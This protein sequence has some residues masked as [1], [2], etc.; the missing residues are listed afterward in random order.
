MYQCFVVTYR[1]YSKILRLS[2]YIIQKTKV[3][4]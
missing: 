3:P 4:G 1:L 2:M